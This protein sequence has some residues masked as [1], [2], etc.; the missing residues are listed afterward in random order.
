MQKPNTQKQ[1]MPQVVVMD[2]FWPF[3]NS[4]E[5]YAAIV[6][7]VWIL[8]ER[9]LVTGSSYSPSFP[10]GTNATYKQTRR[11]ISDHSPL[12]PSAQEAGNET[13]RMC[14]V[15]IVGFLWWSDCGF[16]V[17]CVSRFSLDFTSFFPIVV[18]QNN[19]LHHWQLLNNTQ[20]AGYRVHLPKKRKNQFF[21]DCVYMH[22]SSQ[23]T[24]RNQVSQVI[25]ERVYVHLRNM[26]TGNLCI[27]AADE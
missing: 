1:L 24:L 18:L 7:F 26:A 6:V 16:S 27:N 9:Y 14:C 4:G 2:K 11:D 10:W 5:Q 23:V 15:E 8:G 25:G 3:E 22:S 17:W 19:S 20:L 12:F 13:G 21:I